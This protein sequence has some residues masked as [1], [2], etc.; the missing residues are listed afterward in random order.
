MISAARPD[1][2]FTL[3]FTNRRMSDGIGEAVAAFLEAEGR[4]GRRYASVI[5]DDGRLSLTVGLL[6][7]PAPP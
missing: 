3:H 6:D 7:D 5:R 2:D 4:A 1:D